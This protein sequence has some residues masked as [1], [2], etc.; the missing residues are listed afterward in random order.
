MKVALAVSLI[1][2][3]ITD[4]TLAQADVSSALWEELGLYKISPLK[5]SPSAYTQLYLVSWVVLSVVIFIVRAYS[6]GDI[7]RWRLLGYTRLSSESDSTAAK[8]SER[9][10]AP[11]RTFSYP[12]TLEFNYFDPDNLP[13]PVQGYADYIFSSVQSLSAE[14][15][16]QVILLPALKNRLFI[17]VVLI[18]GG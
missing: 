6:S 12:D 8:N 9:R 13:R 4:A 5:T 1:F 15:G 10:S 11:Q 18:V 16:F 3:L 17:A 2:L 7:S 14:I